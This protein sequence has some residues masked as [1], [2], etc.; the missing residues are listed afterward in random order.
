MIRRL[1]IHLLARFRPR[2]IAAGYELP[3]LTSPF[4]E[5]ERAFVASH[6]MAG[7][8][9]DYTAQSIAYVEQVAYKLLQWHPSEA[10]AE[11]EAALTEDE[12]RHQA[13]RLITMAGSY[14][15]SVVIIVHGGKWVGSADARDDLAV[16]AIGETSVRCQPFRLVRDRVLGDGGNLWRW[17]KGLKAE[18]EKERK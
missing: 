17:Y 10:E 8:R 2:R 7:A 9:V 14:L 4:A 5:L 18:V 1:V 3:E 16:E 13:E 15:G 11:A 12:W 6:R